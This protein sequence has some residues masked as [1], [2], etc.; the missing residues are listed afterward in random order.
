MVVL[1]RPSKPGQMEQGNWDRRLNELAEQFTARCRRSP[2]QRAPNGWQ[3][4]KLGKQGPHPQSNLSSPG[5]FYLETVSRPQLYFSS[6]PRKAAKLGEQCQNQLK[7]LPCHWPVSGDHDSERAH[8][9]SQWKFYWNPPLRP[10][11]R[12][13][14]V[15][16]SKA[17]TQKIQGKHSYSGEQLKPFPFPPS[18]SAAFLTGTHLLNSK[19]MDSGNLSQANPLILS[20][21]PPFLWFPSELRQF[22]LGSLV[23]SSR[24]SPSLFHCPQL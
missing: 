23:A 11:L 15:R 10:P 13:L 4:T 24:L 8:Q 17:S 1:R 12:F 5:L 9:E 19:A 14:P 7:T 2:E 21:K 18:S 16:E 6:K 22:N 3:G 20:S